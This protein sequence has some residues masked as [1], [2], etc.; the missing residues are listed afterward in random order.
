MVESTGS[1]VETWLDGL[2]PRPGGPAF[3]L[4]ERAR[5]LNWSHTIVPGCRAD[6]AAFV[7]LAPARRLML[8]RNLLFFA[9]AD[10]AVI[11]LLTDAVTDLVY[12]AEEPWLPGLDLYGA[13][14]FLRYH[15]DIEGVH[16][17]VYRQLLEGV[18]GLSEHAALDEVLALPGVMR[19]LE[20]MRRIGQTSDAGEL[21]FTWMLA[22][23][24]FLQETF[25]CIL[26][27]SPRDFPAVVDANRRIRDD[28]NLHAE[29]AALLF[30]SLRRQPPPARL[31]AIVEEVVAVCDAYVADVLP[32][33]LADMSPAMLR[34]YARFRADV[35]LGRVGQPP[36]YG[37]ENPLPWLEMNGQLSVP[38]MHETRPTAYVVATS[39]PAT[40]RLLSL[41][42]C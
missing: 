26:Y 12:G 37:V 5:K 15:M 21:V 36:A 35:L 31:R 32:D 14:L 3:E 6:R 11:D 18:V 30:R 7:A 25:A 42:D 9:Y 13:R 17:L 24:L 19:K 33:T 4:Y 22:E 23:G 28:E 16:A 20:T 29:F 10:G 38:N 8:Q 34:Q 27:F 41:D 1:T 2:F 39:R 40:G